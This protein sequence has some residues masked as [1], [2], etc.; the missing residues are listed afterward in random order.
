M[1]YT[2]RLNLLRCMQYYSKLSEEE[3][4]IEIENLDENQHDYKCK[5]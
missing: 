1:S 4:E 5:S 3:I 2:V